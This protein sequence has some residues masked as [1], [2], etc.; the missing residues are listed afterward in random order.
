MSLLEIILALGLMSLLGS[1]GINNWFQYQQRLKLDIV[2]AQLLT[3]LI[4]VQSA[5]NWTN[6]NYQLQTYQHDSQIRL[7]AIDLNN[8][9]TIA[10]FDFK[11]AEKSVGLKESNLVSPVV[12]YG[13]RNMASPGHFILS[14]GNDEIRVIVSARGRIRRCTQIQDKATQPVM[15]IPPC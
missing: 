13:E 12:F 14:N 5:A 7:K 11:S 6:R 10:Q 15:G 4:R 2:S 9:Q 8:L 1:I 3:F